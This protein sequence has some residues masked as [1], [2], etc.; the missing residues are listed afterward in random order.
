VAEIGTRVLVIADGDKKKADALATRLGEELV[1]LRGKTTPP[2]LDVK[3]GVGEGVAF[4]DLPV[5]IADP[6]DN[7]GGGAPSDNT[8]ILRHLIDSKVEN[9]CLGPIWDPIAVRICFDAGLGAK[10]GLRM[11]GKIAPSSGQPVDAEVEIIGLKRD[12]WQRF[13]PTHV[14][15]GDCAAVRVGGVDVVL[16][17]KRT[18]ATG[19]ELF[20]NVGI[21][22]TQKKIVVVKST[23]HFMAAYGPIAKKV[24]YVESSGPLR[25]DHRKVPYTKVERPIWPLDQDAKPRGLIF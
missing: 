19:L 4:N 7:A 16:I 2:Y 10:I 8:D 15:V 9:A 13:G 25:R 6:A 17:T 12:A 20:T 18:Q 21:D 5:V 1:S 23:N 3:G 24:V 11:G 22:P 14:P